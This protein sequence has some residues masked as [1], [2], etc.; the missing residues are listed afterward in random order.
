VNLPVLTLQ[1]C[2]LGAGGIAVGLWARHFPF[3]SP[4]VKPLLP[5]E[6]RWPTEQVREWALSGRPDAG[7]LAFFERD[8]ERTVPPGNDL[9]APADGVLLEVFVKGGRR[10]AV[11]ALSYWDVHVQRSPCA[12]V[13]REVREHGDTLM[14]GEGAAAVFL[15]DK[16]APVQKVVVLDTAA[17]PVEVRLVTSLSARRVEVWVEPGRKLA[18]GER[19]GRILMGSTVVLDVPEQVD[20]VAAVGSRVVAG[21]TVLSK[22]LVR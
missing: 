17:G 19:I 2:L 15:R 10:Y 22:E 4:V 8:P 3:P 1:C 12:A 13:V 9:V 16:V 11:I 5:P 14:D 21:E 20:I 18:K 7:F 6:Q